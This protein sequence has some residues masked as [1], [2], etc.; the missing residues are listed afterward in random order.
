MSSKACPKS[1]NSKLQQQLN[2]TLTYILIIN[3]NHLVSSLKRLRLP[4]DWVQLLPYL[5]LKRKCPEGSVLYS[6]AV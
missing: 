2:A 6:T 3:K 5:H 1:F 4:Y